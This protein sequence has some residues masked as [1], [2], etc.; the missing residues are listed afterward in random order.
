MVKA[1]PQIVVSFPEPSSY[2]SLDRSG[3]SRSIN[4]FALPEKSDKVPWFNNKYV[5]LVFTYM[6]LA[7]A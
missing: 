5:P 7:Q 6:A 3:L 4:P 2:F 1:A